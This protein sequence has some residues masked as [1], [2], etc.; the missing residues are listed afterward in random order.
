MY[1]R[2]ATTSILMPQRHNLTNWVKHLRAYLGSFSLVQSDAFWRSVPAPCTV[3]HAVR[4]IEAIRD[5]M[6]IIF[7]IFNSQV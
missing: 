1:S 3:L 6:S 7:F 5:K 2:A 4:V